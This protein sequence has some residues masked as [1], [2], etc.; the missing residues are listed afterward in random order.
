MGIPW[1]GYD[2]DAQT[3]APKSWLTAAVYNW[4][5]VLPQAGQ[6]RDGRHVEVELLLG[7][8][9][10]QVHRPRAVRRRRLG[11]D[12]GRHRRQDGAIKKGSFYEF[13]GPIYDQSGKLRV[14]KGKKLGLKDIL[15]MN[16]LVKGVVGSPKG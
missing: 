4:G 7:R 10:R 9:E 5:H 2:S 1:V 14:P 11:Q 15:A 8:L 3:F 13:Q 6:G 12:E 16:W